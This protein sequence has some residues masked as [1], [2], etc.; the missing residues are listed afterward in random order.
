VPERKIHQTVIFFMNIKTLIYIAILTIAVIMVWRH[1]AEKYAQDKHLTIE[2]SSERLNFEV[3]VASSPKRKARGLM[4]RESLPDRYGMLFVWPS[5]TH[6]EM[7]MKNTP[8]SLDMIFIDARGR[9]VHIAHSTTPN[10]KDIIT[11]ST[12]A[13]AVLEVAG[14]T[15]KAKHIEEGNH[16]IH[17]VFAP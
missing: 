17:P 1:P 7:W 3:D 10:S 13:Q 4:S 9:I 12:P 5:E 8:L 11:S 16:V 15:A 2:T 14:G 6:I